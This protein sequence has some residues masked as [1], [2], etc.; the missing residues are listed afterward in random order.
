M[1]PKKQQQAADYLDSDDDS[2]DEIGQPAGENAEM[3]EA[4]FI[5]TALTPIRAGIEV[6][7]PQRMNLHVEFVG[8]PH[9]M[10]EV[11]SK[12]KWAIA[13]HMQR[14][15]KDN[16]AV[17]DRHLA[18]DEDMVGASNRVI[19]LG[20]T[21]NNHQN[22]FPFAV[23]F[24]VPG[25]MSRTLTRNNK[26]VYVVGSNQAPPGHPVDVF[27][28]S[29]IVNKWQLE[30]ME[31][32]LPEDI[33]RDITHTDKGRTQIAVGSLPHSHLKTLI[34]NRAFT[35][36][37]LQGVEVDRIMDPGYDT[38]VEVPSAIGKQLE[39][40]LR[41]A[42]EQAS[43]G[44]LDASKWNISIHRADGHRDWASENDLVGAMVSSKTVDPG[45]MSTNLLHKVCVASIDATLVF[46]TVV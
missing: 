22:T 3:D 15:F 34:G 25:I 20:I 9:Q 31:E 28:P 17:H 24:E 45:V 6:K 8:S 30:N 44:L 23:G 21:I 14:E 13:A 38:I 37:E 33:D 29:H 19:P 39:N 41:P 40:T 4:A 10:A 36:A 46:R 32:C 12:A 11:A 18:G 35:A 2:Y 7:R 1:F 5:Q 42:V 27:D 26:S 16:L 43:K